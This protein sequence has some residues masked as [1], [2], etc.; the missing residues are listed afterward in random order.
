MPDYDRVTISA[1][2][3]LTAL[4]GIRYAHPHT[5]KKIPISKPECRWIFSISGSSSMSEK[6]ISSPPHHSGT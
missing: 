2:H 6:T 4:L 3:G 5:K 1:G